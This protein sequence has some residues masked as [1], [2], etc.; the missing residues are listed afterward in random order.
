MSSKSRIED[1]SLFKIHPSDEDKDLYRAAWETA[2]ANHGDIFTFYLPGMI[3][4]GRQRGLYPAIS[5]TG[6][7][8]GLQCEHCKGRL[9]ENMVKA[10]CCQWLHLQPLFPDPAASAFPVFGRGPQDPGFI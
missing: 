10:W 2:R 8:C 9:L 3:R 6:T 1:T 5:I 4:L 7:R